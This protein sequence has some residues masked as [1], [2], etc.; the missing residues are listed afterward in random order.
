MWQE[1]P[2]VWLHL[3][4]T[5]GKIVLSYPSL[6]AQL[7]LKERKRSVEL[8][9]KEVANIVIPFNKDQL[10]FL[11]Q[12]S[13]DW[14]VALIDFRG[15]ILFHLPSSPLLHFLK[16]HPV[17]FLKKFSIQPLE[18]TILLFTDGSS[19][20]K[21]VTIIIGKSHVQVTEETSAK[22]AESRA[23]I[24]GF[25]HVRDCTFNL[26]TASR[27]I[28]ELFPHIETANIPEN[29]TTIFSLLFDS[30]KE[31]KHRDKKYFVGH[32]GAHS[33]LP[34]PLHEGNALADALTKAIALNLHKKIDK[35]KSSL[36]IH[37]QN[38]AGLRYE[39]H[40]HRGSS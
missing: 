11:L 30:Q 24:W 31:I 15:Q 34:G 16:T 32:S 18:R 8:L 1:G 25:Q 28:V 26:L 17:I 33:S 13:D 23:V 39:F 38:A 4:V 20:G 12:N 29:K 36:K 9:R 3:P 35:A 5:P 14:Q 7:I 10:Q 22:R 27:Y 6:V 19:N 2:L 21:A 40:I 37:H